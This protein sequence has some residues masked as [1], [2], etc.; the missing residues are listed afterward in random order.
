MKSE[1][2][3]MVFTIVTAIAYSTLGMKDDR[4]DIPNNTVTEVDNCWTSE[5]KED[6]LDKIWDYY[7]YWY[8]ELPKDAPCF[9][10]IAP[11]FVNHVAYDCFVGVLN[12]DSETREIEKVVEDYSER[13]KCFAETELMT[14][15]LQK[16]VFMEILCDCEGNILC[17][18]GLWDR[19]D[20]KKFY[21]DYKS[22][23]KWK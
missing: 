4:S 23:A 13:T 3:L 22:Q 20:F 8:R 9:G 14:Y 5:E 1:L 19:N 16:Q 17:P 2:K 12:K 10:W 7:Y 11:E 6:K 18:S 15:L 21:R